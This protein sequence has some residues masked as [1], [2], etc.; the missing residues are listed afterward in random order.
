MTDQEKRKAVE[1][2]AREAKRLEEMASRAEEGML[3][4]LLA[5][6]QQ[7]TERILTTAPDEG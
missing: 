1:T 5:M 3:G 4:Y 7:E 6:V 2:I